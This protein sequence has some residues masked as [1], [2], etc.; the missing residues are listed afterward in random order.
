MKTIRASRL[1]ALVSATSVLALSAPAF[2][3]DADDAEERV[4]PNTIIV[5]AQKREQNLQDVPISITAFTS[6]QIESQRI[7]GVEDIGRLTPGVAVTPNPA[8]NNGVRVY[9]R[10]VGTLDPQIGQDSRV[11]IY[12]DGVYLGKT[13]GLAFDLPDLERVEILKGPQGTLYGRNS[14]AG[15]VNLISARPSGEWEGKINAEYGRFNQWKLSGLINIPV[16]D[17]GGLRISGVIKEQDGWIE[18]NGPGV[19]FGGGSAQALRVAFG[20]ELTPDL[21][22]DVSVD[23]SNSELEPLFYQSVPG[24]AN[25]GSLFAAAVSTSDGR[26]RQVTTSFTNEEGKNEQFGGNVSVEW[27]FAENH[28]LK[29]LGA[30]RRV[31]SSRFVTLVPTANPQILGG[32]LNADII[33]DTQVPGVQSFNNLIAGTALAFQLTGQPLR[34]DFTSAFTR[35]VGPQSGLFLSP[36]GGGPTLDGHEQ[37]S[38]EATFNGD[39]ADGRLEYTLGAFYY[40]EFT[41]SGFNDVGNPFDVNSYLFVLAGFNPAIGTPI[42]TGALTAGGLAP[43]QAVLPPAQFQAIVDAQ[44]GPIVGNANGPLNPVTLVGLYGEARQSAANDL[45]IDTEAFAL[46]G[47]LTFNITDA[48]SITGGLRYSDESKSGFQQPKSPFFLDNLDL[49]GRVI[50]PNIADIGFDVLNWSAVIEYEPDD[51]FLFYAS[52]KQSFRSGGFNAAAVGPRLPGQTFGA[53]FVFGRE[54]IAAYEAGAKTVFADGRIRLNVAGFYYD[55]TDQQTTV[56]LNPLIATSRAIVNT[57]EEIW[58]FEIDALAQVT[59]SLT[60]FASYSWID[61]DAGDVTNPL[62]GQVEVRDQLQGTPENSF[63]VGFDFDT[64]LTEGVGLFANGSYYYQDEQLSIPQNNLFL[65]DRNIVSGRIGVDFAVGNSDMSVWIWGENLLDDKYTVDSLPFETFAYRTV[66][67]GQPA[68][69]GL[70]ASIKF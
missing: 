31:D 59:D 70:G 47:E 69:Y 53:D 29:V 11:A 27:D 2:A 52:Y 54:D 28:R 68:T 48:L 43:L 6:E 50:P 16:S 63:R 34:S 49:L 37:Y 39:F 46:Y 3:Q 35:G 12:Q 41:S 19:D 30:Y 22:V 61:G 36:A 56:A 57:D 21:R 44:L 23:Y 51:D 64:Q 55:F 45:R 4:D 8:D 40:D 24:S 20:S 66:V 15:A 17:T 9:I 58:G 67:F 65:T 62:T 33:P 7:E 32:I 1:I 5:T 60:L 26:Q 13:Q 38:L 14:V 18:N 10:G 25:P 42:V